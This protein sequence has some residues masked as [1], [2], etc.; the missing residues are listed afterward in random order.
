MYQY[1]IVK[2]RDYKHFTIERK[3]T[4]LIGFFS[5]WDY[6]DA[7]CEYIEA[8][9]FCLDEIEKDKNPEPDIKVLRVFKP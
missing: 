4:G 7:K 9:K 6:L 8:T 2:K 5:F 1:R 3:R